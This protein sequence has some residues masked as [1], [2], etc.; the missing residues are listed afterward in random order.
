MAKK[1]LT[2]ELS[3]QAPK[4]LSICTHDVRVLSAFKSS[5]K[6]TMEQL[7]PIIQEA[8]KTVCEKVAQS[9]YATGALHLSGKED[10][11]HNKINMEI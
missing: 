6:L 8:F 11:M 3:K 5:G 2:E 9:S 4:A 1:D 7:G 10:E